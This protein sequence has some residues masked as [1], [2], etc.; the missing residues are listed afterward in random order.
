MAP[1]KRKFPKGQPLN[2]FLL[3]TK[4]K[5]MCSRAQGL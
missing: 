3:E 1:A 2:I 4:G 5:K